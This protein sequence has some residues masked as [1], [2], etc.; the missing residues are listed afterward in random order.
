MVSL[1]AKHLP[2]L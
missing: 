1:P 2:Q